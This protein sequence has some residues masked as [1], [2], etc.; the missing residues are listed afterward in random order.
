VLFLPFLGSWVAIRSWG[1]GVGKVGH[2]GLA[3]LRS[4]IL[5]IPVPNG[6]GICPA[7]GTQ[8]ARTTREGDRFILAVDLRAA[9]RFRSAIDDIP[10]VLQLLLSVASTALSL[11]LI[12]IR[13][14]A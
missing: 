13:L 12:P 5:A 9:P 3:F 6:A 10:Q 4:W 7:V 1:L 2:H 11:P 8:R 14:A